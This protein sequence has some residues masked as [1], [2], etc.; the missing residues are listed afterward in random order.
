[1]K[2]IA[3]VS[4]VA[5]LAI[6]VLWLQREQARGTFDVVERA[7]V[8]WLAANTGGHQP[9]PS[10]T[11]VLYDDEASE[12]A[13]T[14][15]LALIDGALFARAAARLGAAAA[16]VEGIQGDPRRMIEAA[17]GMPVF[18]GYDWRNPPGLGWTPLAGEPAATWE[19]VPGLAGRRARFA[20]GFVAPPEGTS[21][22]RSVLLAGRNGDR[23]VPSFLALAWAV[24]NGS[25]WSE[26]SV[27]GAVITAGSARLTLDAGGAALFLPEGAPAVVSMNELLVASE[28]FEREGG[29]SPFRD[30][31]MVL[32][33]ATAD[34]ARVAVDGAGAI[35][36]A[37]RWASAWEAV[38]TNRLFLRPGWWYPFAVLAAGT[39]LVLG[40]AR[41]SNGAAVLAGFF[42]VLVFA[43]LA[44]GIFGS[45]RVLLPAAPTL[46]TLGAAVVLGRAGH[47][48]GWFGK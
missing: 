6:L 40:P 14:K 15:R 5:V 20:R 12:L 8:S 39:V 19:E 33:P 48:A 30:H 24:A 29:E 9:L 23:A 27:E 11:L 3:V 28:K 7:F 1:M 22:E 43:L 47:R 13:G 38:R 45:E 25:R 37:E 31:V 34:I 41:R 42:T 21:G 10:L 44:L 32:A 46:L 16:G 26:V 4:V 17:G 2:R 35:T 18:G 36:P